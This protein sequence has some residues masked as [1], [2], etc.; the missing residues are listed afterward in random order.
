[1]TNPIWAQF[2]LTNIPIYRTNQPGIRY[3]ASVHRMLQLAANI[4]DSTVNTN[5]QSGLF[6]GKAPPPP[7]FRY[8]SVFRPVFGL[9]TNGTNVGINIIG[10]VQVSGSNASPQVYNQI[11]RSNYYDLP[12]AYTLLL[13][14]P[15]SSNINISGIPWIVGATK[16][17]PQFYQYSY[18]TGFLYERKLLF[19]RAAAGGGLP[20]TNNPP[21]YTN[22]FYVM[23]ATNNFG[24]DAFNPY[25]YPF[26]G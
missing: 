6:K 10:Y 13:H 9:G 19:A 26:T 22:Q 1:M 25:P 14:N 18:D 5:V 11:A 21:Q 20:N 15:A 7:N 16:G 12:A 8:P 3:N 4:Y 24:M 17:L 23:A 2:G